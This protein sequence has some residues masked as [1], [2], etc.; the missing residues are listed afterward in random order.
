MA[1]GGPSV[2]QPW[3]PVE[4]ENFFNWNI[5]ISNM[6]W[7]VGGND[8]WRIASETISGI[9]SKFPIYFIVCLR[10]VSPSYPRTGTRSKTL[11]S[12]PEKWF[13]PCFCFPISV[14]RKNHLKLNEYY[15]WK[16][17]ERFSL[18][19]IFGPTI[20]EALDI[21]PSNSYRKTGTRGAATQ[22]SVGA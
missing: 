4:I 12:I 13:Q 11:D 2:E 6:T 9:T 17:I 7:P 10:N 22:P 8:D 15:S 19:F 1:I 21:I 16:R 20:F 14:F 3:P 18:D 5:R